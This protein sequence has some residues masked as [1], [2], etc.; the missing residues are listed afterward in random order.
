MITAANINYHC[1]Y[2][3]H[4]LLYSAT[5]IAAVFSWVAESNSDRFKPR[6]EARFTPVLRDRPELRVLRLLVAPQI[7]LPLKRASTQVTRKR[8]E[9]RV[10]ATV[11]Y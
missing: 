7:H 4:I 1:V 6:G 5:R 11:C 9:P 2:L 8:L 10:F 3:S